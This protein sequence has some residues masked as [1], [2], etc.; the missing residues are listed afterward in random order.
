MKLKRGL[1]ARNSDHEITISGLWTTGGA[2]RLNMDGIRL[3]KANSCEN[4]ICL[5]KYSLSQ[6]IKI[7]YL[8]RI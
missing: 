7:A 4:I 3:Q 5:L 1:V 6:L 2:E 8:R